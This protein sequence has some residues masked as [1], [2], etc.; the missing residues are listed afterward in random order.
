[1]AIKDSRH[2]HCNFHNKGRGTK[3]AD[4]YSTTVPGIVIFTIGCINGGKRRAAVL[5]QRWRTVP[6]IVIFTTGCLNGG[7]RRAAVLKQRW[8][9]VPGIVIFTIGCLNGGERRAAIF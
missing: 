9:T 7:K 4:L 3:M 8:R 5:K 6:G 2:W 1:V